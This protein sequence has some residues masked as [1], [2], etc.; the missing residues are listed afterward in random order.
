MDI[1]G[2][3]GQ[4]QRAVRADERD[5]EPTRIV[6]ATQVYPTGIDD[7][8]DAMTNPERLPRWFLPVTGDL[9]VGWRYQFE[10][11]RPL[12]VE[13]QGLKFPLALPLII[14][15]LSPLLNILLILNI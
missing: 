14:V 13:K 3:A 7:V 10:G 6:L 4:V 5:G 15:I 11:F 8:W 2:Q 12:Y 9:T 1:A